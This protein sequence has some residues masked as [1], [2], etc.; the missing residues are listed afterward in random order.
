MADEFKIRHTHPNGFRSGEWAVIRAVM[1]GHGRDCY[2]VE[3]P[4][5]VTDFWAVDDPDE[6]YEF[7]PVQGKE[8]RHDP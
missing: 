5:G 2:L 1:S 6:P 3:F 7:E 4:D 8:E